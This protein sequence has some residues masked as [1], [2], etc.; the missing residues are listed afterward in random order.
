MICSCCRR[1]EATIKDYRF[2]DSIGC[3]GKI[4]VCKYCYNLTDE[5]FIVEYCKEV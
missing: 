5:D 3:Q 2:I 4:L 1:T